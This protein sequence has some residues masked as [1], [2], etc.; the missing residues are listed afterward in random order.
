MDIYGVKGCTLLITETIHSH[1]TTTT[2]STS[3][4]FKI[5]LLTCLNLIEM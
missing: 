2:I 3:R 5:T 1:M 4:M